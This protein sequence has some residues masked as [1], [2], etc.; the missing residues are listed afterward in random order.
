MDGQLHRLASA[1]SGVQ[2]ARE[3]YVSTGINQQIMSPDPRWGRLRADLESP[4]LS[5]EVVTVPPPGRSLKSCF[6]LR[7]DRA[8]EVWETRHTAPRPSIRLFGRFA[9]KDVFVA[10]VWAY[11]QDFADKNDPA[12]RVP[13]VQTTT[14]WRN[15][16]PAYSPLSGSYPDDYLSNA[17]VLSSRR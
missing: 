4:F 6:M 17:Y 12:Y 13:I 10:L 14:D 5:G 1:V 2:V 15:L 8:D 16:F 11:R 3:I 7:L 9:L